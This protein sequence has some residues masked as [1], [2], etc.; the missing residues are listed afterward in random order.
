[1]R[2]RNAALV[3]ALAAAAGVAGIAYAQG[4]A[5]SGQAPAAQA[6]QPG[7]GVAPCAAPPCGPGHPY[8]QQHAGGPRGGRMMMM[9]LDADRDGEVSRAELQSSQQRQLERFDKADANGDGK[10]S[11]D[12][13]RTLRE[14]WRGQWREMAPGQN[15]PQGYP[16]AARQG[17]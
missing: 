13:M 8:R 3:A 1:M 15:C 7:P 11:A 12:E 9:M 14:Q 2:L 10:L 6:V 5:P 4:A 17:A 16:G